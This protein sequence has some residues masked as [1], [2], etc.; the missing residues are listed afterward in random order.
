MHSFNSPRCSLTKLHQPSHIPGLQALRGLSALLVFCQHIFW[1]A[2][3]VTPGLEQTLYRL[4]FGGIGVLCFFALSAFLVSGKASDPPKRF[5]AERLRRIVPGF[6]LALLLASALDYMRLGVNGLTW[7][8]FFFLPV[9]MQPGVTVPYWTLYYEVLLYLVIFFIARLSPRWVAPFIVLWA[10]VAWIWQDRPYGNGHYLFPTWYHLVFPIFA[11]FFA[12]GIWVAWCAQRHV[13]ES[14]RHSMLVLYTVLACMCFQTPLLTEW[15]PGFATVLYEWP[16]L[17]LPKLLHGD[18]GMLYFLAGTACA[19]RAALLWPARGPIG[20]FLRRMGDYSYGIY[21]MHIAIIWVGIWLLQLM[22]LFP[23]YITTA[24]LLTAF[25]LPLSVICGWG[26]FRL[27][28]W[29]KSQDQRRTHLEH[30]EPVQAIPVAGNS[31]IGP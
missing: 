23:S 21:L 5:L 29:L 30:A 28:Q 10:V 1:Q 14:R 16:A 26:E 11:G 6:W 15:L 8:V 2:S 4:N 12:S 27:Q 25:S 24:L 13:A 17:I 9:G 19:L 3:I 31:V 20:R 22:G 7:Q 18:I